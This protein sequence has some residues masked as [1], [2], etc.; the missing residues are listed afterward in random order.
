M[1]FNHPD[2]DNFYRSFLRDMENIEEF[3]IRDA[4]DVKIKSILN[5]DIY[6]KATRFLEGS[7][8]HIIYNC[9]LIRGDEDVET[10]RVINNLKG[11]NNPKFENIKSIFLDELNFNIEDG[12]RSNSYSGR[13]KSTLNEIVNNRHRNVHASEDVSEW[14]NSNRKDLNT[15]KREFDGMLNILS[16]LDKI[17]YSSD[18]NSFVVEVEVIEEVSF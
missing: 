7:I 17:T 8:K 11:L 1:K 4:N 14:Y 10:E 12:L 5:T 16:Y 6:T 15:F 13:D 2:I 9:S 3:K 18:A